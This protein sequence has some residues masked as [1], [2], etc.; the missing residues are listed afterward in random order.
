MENTT[1]DS[2]FL[3]LTELIQRDPMNGIYI[4]AGLLLGVL[5]FIWFIKSLFERRDPL[6]KKLPDCIWHTTVKKLDRIYDGD[7]FYCH[8]K[9][10]NPIDNKPV[11]I[12]IRGIDTAEMKDPDPK[13][14]KKAQKAKEIVTEELKRAKTIHLY[15]VNLKDKYGRVLAT[16][17]CDRRDL[18]KILIE[19]KLA[20]KYD[21]GKKEKW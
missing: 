17:F 20:K 7:T 11:G 19:E 4:A 6:P 14:Q 9:G 16:V 10:H 13:N 15:N 21:G 12:R 3:F 1:T 18:A 5:V 8:I 2:I